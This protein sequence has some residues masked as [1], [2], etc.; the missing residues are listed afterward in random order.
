MCSQEFVNVQV[1]KQPANDE[2]LI[3]YFYIYCSLRI[4]FMYL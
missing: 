2:I 4:I 3:S 1:Q